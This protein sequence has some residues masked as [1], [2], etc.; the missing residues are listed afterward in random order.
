MASHTNRRFNHPLEATGYDDENSIFTKW[1]KNNRCKI[2]SCYSNRKNLL[3]CNRYRRTFYDY[4]E[5]RYQSLFNSDDLS[6]YFKLSYLCGCQGVNGGGW[7][8]YVGQEKC[9]PIEGWCN[10]LQRLAGHEL[11]M[12]LRFYL[13][14]INGNTKSQV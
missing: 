4:Y 11:Q 14:Q 7:A 10:R 13:L 6:S 9:R 12:L 2:I 8:H 3:K 1:Q 5:G